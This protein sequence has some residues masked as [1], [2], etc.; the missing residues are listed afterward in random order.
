MY[1]KIPILHF[2]MCIN[3]IANVIGEYLVGAICVLEHVSTTAQNTHTLCLRYYI[4]IYNATHFRSDVK[5]PHLFL[6]ALKH[7]HIVTQQT[8]AALN[9]SDEEISDLVQW[10]D[11]MVFDYISSQKDRF[12][13]LT[14]HTISECISKE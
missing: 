9:L 5:L 6:E 12:V 14:T 7:G 3:L 13:V 4:Y 8:L 11:L 10:T 2:A 1:H